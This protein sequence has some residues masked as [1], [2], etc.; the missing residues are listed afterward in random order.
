[1][2]D[3]AIKFSGID[4]GASAMMQK[5][6]QQSKELGNGMI[7]DARQYSQ[8]AKEQLSYLE[9]QIKATEKR[10]ALER[11]S[12]EIEAKRQL[13]GGDLSQKM[14]SIA[15]DYAMED[16]S[17]KLLREILDAI[18]LTS[19]EEI[20]SDRK[21]VES[22][23]KSFRSDPNKF[24]PE[25]QLKLSYQQD[26]L[27]TK[28]KKDGGGIMGEV[29]TGTFLANALSNALSQLSNVATSRDEE[30][31]V[32][33]V[34]SSIPLIGELIGSTYGRGREEQLR[35]G[36]ARGNFGAMSGQTKSTLGRFNY[37]GYTGSEGL[38]MSSDAYRGAGGN[39]NIEDYLA[40]Q[41]GFGVDM[42]SALSTNRFS[43]DNNI[44]QMIDRMLGIMQ[45]QGVDRS[46]LSEYL[47]KQTQFTSQMQSVNPNF[48]MAKSNEIFG[49]YGQIGGAFSA[50]NPQFSNYI[51]TIQRSISNPQ[52]D[53][54]KAQNISMLRK[55]NPESSTFDIMA[56][57]EEGGIELQ[58][59]AFKDILDRFGTGDE[60][61][62]AMKA[63]TGLGYN[64]VNELFK[65]GNID[66]F[67][68]N[69][70]SFE[71]ITAGVNLK[72][73][74][75]KRTTKL[76]ASAAGT[77]DDY[78]SEF[79]A[80]RGTVSATSKVFVELAE[81]AKVLSKTFMDF[82]LTPQAIFGWGNDPDIAKPK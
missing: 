27:A 16:L 67:A 63:R 82:K 33:S 62:F 66:D 38:E 59:A 51:S 23:L 58:Q 2:A 60:A 68:N 30:Q 56:L 20:S 72:G 22:N 50:N 4:S 61:K 70:K 78:A 19:K 69:R 79:G 37:M 64:V 42:S 17:T 3:K 31:G 46:L 76:D 14:S 21:N 74:A 11:Q 7:A 12:L 49:Q 75:G 9:S 65:S 26:L 77:T 55:M 45:D 1:M 18:R 39:I 43:G 32:Q 13:K 80:F 36:Q 24:S 6:R 40:A 71:D 10:N 29:F 47:E 28:D 44:P 73:E 54:M 81:T 53:L 57:Q 25:D 8:V 15:S 34:M 41:R 52:N 35:Y 5:M 48:N